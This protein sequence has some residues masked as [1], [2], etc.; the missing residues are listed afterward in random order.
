MYL[1]VQH[2]GRNVWLSLM[3]IIII[4]L[5]VLSS[6]VLIST[7]ALTEAAGTILRS[8]IDVTVDFLPNVSQEDAAQVETRVKELPD[9]D[10]VELVDAQEVYRRFTE[11]IQ[12]N[13]TL[14]A[15]LQLVEKNPF[16]PRLYVRAKTLAGYTTV[17]SAFDD[18]TIVPPSLVQ[19]KNF[20]DRGEAIRRFGLVEQRVRYAVLL[21]VAF[22]VLLS[23]FVIY[24]TVRLTIYT[25]REEIGIMKLVGASNSFIRLPFIVE[26]FL[27]SLLAVGI[28]AAVIIPV[29]GYIDPWLGGLFAPTPFS[30]MGYYQQHVWWV[31]GL[32]AGIIV[33]VNMFSSALAVGRYLKV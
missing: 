30:L 1:A 28:G 10:S 7:S 15:G 26:S 5:A 13:T 21:L 27:L 19:K 24:H 9:V 12:G 31:V 20:D 23:L 16:G 2:I 17:L 33:C 32:Q 4:F 6:H 8:K 11:R 3:T 14:A 18:P 29:F 22:F 25:H